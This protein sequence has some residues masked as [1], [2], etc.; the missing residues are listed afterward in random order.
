MKARLFALPLVCSAML[1]FSAIS[2][3]S[4]T[5]VTFDNLNETGTGS[6]IPSGYQGLVWSNLVGMTV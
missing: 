6:F 1:A 4:Q 3:R 2:T 5:V